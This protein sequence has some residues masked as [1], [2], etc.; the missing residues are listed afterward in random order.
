MARAE[1]RWTQ[2][3]PAGKKPVYLAPPKFRDA[4]RANQRKYR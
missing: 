3:K 1:A 4:T 2:P